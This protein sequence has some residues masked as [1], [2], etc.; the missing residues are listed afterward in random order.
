M[1]SQGS[2]HRARQRIRGVLF[3]K[4]GTLFEY[5]GTWVPIIFEAAAMAAQG[6]ADLVSRLV[7]AAGYDEARRQIRAGSLFAGGDTIELAD[8]WRQLGVR[9][10]QAD[11]VTSLDALFARLAPAMSV[12]V[13]DL[14]ALF[15]TLTGRGLKLGLATNDVEASARALMGR[16]ALDPFLS[17]QAGYDSGHGAKPEPGMTLAFCERVGLAPE[18]VAVV[19]DNRHDLDMGRAAGAGLLVGVLTGTSA[20][21]DLAPLADAV[22]ESV[23]D[24]PSLLDVYV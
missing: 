16:F 8:R 21:A 17:F 22:I 3:D 5:H 11:L 7:D 18:S 14:P 13:T 2:E 10:E 19:G 4:D 9:R 23:A 15:S 24:L 6:D 20:Y 1:G 12:P